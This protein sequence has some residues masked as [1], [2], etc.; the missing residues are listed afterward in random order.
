M[1]VDARQLHLI[2]VPQKLKIKCITLRFTWG[3][4]AGAAAET[5]A[6]CPDTAPV[7]HGDW[8]RSR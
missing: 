4:A 3:T 8:P 7:L 2:S 1:L 5:A 6:D